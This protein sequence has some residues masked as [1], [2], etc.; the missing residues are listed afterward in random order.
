MF[1]FFLI[2]GLIKNL[3][4]LQRMGFNSQYKCIPTNSIMS[5]SLQWMRN[6][7]EQ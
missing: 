1:L 3:V 5:N 4:S 6:H 7:Q 2:R